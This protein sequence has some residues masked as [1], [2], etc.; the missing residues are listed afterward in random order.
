MNF[1]RLETTLQTDVKKQ[2]GS[3]PDSSLSCV[4]CNVRCV[5]SPSGG[6][7]L[8]TW[9]NSKWPTSVPHFFSPLAWRFSKRQLSLSWLR[10]FTITKVIYF[11][12]GISLLSDAR[13]SAINH[14]G[15]S[16]INVILLCENWIQVNRKKSFKSITADKSNYI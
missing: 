12:A 6:I 11:P 8:Q 9:S 5:K 4:N 3:W 16:F 1:L 10:C 15:Q 14:Q 13:A 7:W 2:A